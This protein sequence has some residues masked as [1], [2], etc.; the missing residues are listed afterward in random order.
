M[1][2]VKTNPSDSRPPDRARRYTRPVRNWRAGEI[3]PVAG[4]AN[5]PSAGPRLIGSGPARAPPRSRS[6]VSRSASGDDAPGGRVTRECRARRWLVPCALGH[7]VTSHPPHS[8]RAVRAIASVRRHGLPPAD[9]RRYS[10]GSARGRGPRGKASSIRS[11]SASVSRRSPGPRVLGGVLGGRRLGD[12]EDRLPLHEEPKGD[13]ARS[14]P[15]SGG[16]L[17][18]QPAALRAGT[19]KM[20]RAEQAIGD[21]GDAVALPPRDHRVLDRALPQVVVPWPM[22]GTWYLVR[23]NR[24]RSI[25]Q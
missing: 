16:D 9:V 10:M 25:R 17:R 3:S 7:W 18:V 8:V 6:Q 15:V 23:P 11:I 2:W 4:G 5:R 14:R 19:G 13:L 21:Q 12:R 22:T 20:P 1:R 24:R